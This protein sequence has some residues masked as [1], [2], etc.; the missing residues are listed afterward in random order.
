MVGEGPGNCIVGSG[1]KG[2]KW[3]ELTL[4]SRKGI[5]K[6]RFIMKERKEGSTVATGHQRTLLEEAGSTASTADGL[7]GDLLNL[8]IQDMLWMFVLANTTSLL[9][10]NWS[11]LYITR[12]VTQIASML[13]NNNS[14][15]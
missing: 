1:Q 9:M 6:M 10:V 8:Y 12:M 13:L 2:R 14:F 7:C 3:E 4:K 5:L 15:T 11:V